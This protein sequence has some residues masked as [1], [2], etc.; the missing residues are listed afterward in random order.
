MEWDAVPMAA[1]I[2][3]GIGTSRLPRPLSRR[4]GDRLELLEE[5][6]GRADL[7]GAEATS[8]H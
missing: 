8:D 1:I 3:S 2:V 7:P 5:R 6:K 4:L